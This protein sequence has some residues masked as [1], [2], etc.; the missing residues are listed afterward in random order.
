MTTYS[1]EAPRKKI[2]KSDQKITE[3]D[4]QDIFLSRRWLIRIDGALH[5]FNGACFIKIDNKSLES[6]ILLVLRDEL[7]ELGNSKK[8]RDVAYLLKTDP[9]VDY[10]PG[11]H[12]GVLGFQNGVLDI[13]TWELLSF[14]SI[15]SPPSPSPSENPTITRLNAMSSPPPFRPITYCLPVNFWSI[16]LPADPNL[17]LSQEMMKGYFANFPVETP[18]ADKFFSD[19]SGGDPLLICRIYEVIGYLLIPDTKAKA[20]F[21]LQGISDSGKSVFGRFLE[22]FFPKDRITSLDISRLGGQYLPEA[23]STSCLNL[24]MD[25]P[26]G[27]LSAKAIANLKMV[28]GDDL[29]TQ[30]VKYKDAKPYRG[31]CKFVFSTNHTLQLPNL[32]PA[33]VNRIICIPFKTS[34]PKGKQDPDLLF[35][36]NAERDAITAKAIFYYRLFLLR[37]RQ[38]SGNHTPRVLYNL[39]PNDTIK[40]FVE[41]ECEIMEET[42]TSTKDLYTAY[43]KYCR[44][45][46]F[47]PVETPG[48]FAQRLS[49]LYET[50]IFPDR[51]REGEKIPRGFMGIYCRS[52]RPIILSI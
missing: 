49:A 23:L 32:D 6:L 4:L 38:F 35:K 52:L 28:T 39:S 33:F 7:R 31:L 11:E 16:P 9:F 45:H 51:W 42:R 50:E 40:R 44:K 13:N 2:D 3:Y 25:L 14:E 22:G 10:V 1:N 37:N 46:N 26:S 19:I 43:N 12:Q 29:M 27:V 15:Y 34:I 48:G 20:F 5:C 8:I 41:D 17:Y 36:L 30:E 24:S 18:V 21:L 47:L